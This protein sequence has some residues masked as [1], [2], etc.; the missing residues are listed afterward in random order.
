LAG[1]VIG[2]YSPVVTTPAPFELSAQRRRELAAEATRLAPA[3]TLSAHPFSE[4]AVAHVRALLARA[5]LVKVR[6]NV[7]DRAA[8]RAAAQELAQRVPARL[9]A[10]LGRVVVLYDPQSAAGPGAPDPH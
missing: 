4:A 9:V 3:A 7:A 10:A 2:G 8:F 6:L 5:D 1:T